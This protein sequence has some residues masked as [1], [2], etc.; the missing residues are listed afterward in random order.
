[1][2]GFD[3]RQDVGD[4][5]HPTGCNRCPVI[6]TGNTATVIE[7]FDSTYSRQTRRSYAFVNTVTAKQKERQAP[8]TTLVLL[9]ADARTFRRIPQSGAERKFSG[10]MP[11]K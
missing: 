7:D 8:R 2:T 11:I 5:G 3:S 9:P 6:G 4:V 1:M 10:Q